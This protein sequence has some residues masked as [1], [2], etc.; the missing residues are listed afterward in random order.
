LA[1]SANNHFG[2]KCS[3]GWKGQV[4]MKKD[5]DRDKDGSRIE[6]R[7]QRRQQVST[8][9]RVEVG[10]PVQ[11]V[12]NRNR[13]ARL[14]EEDG[15]HLADIGIVQAKISVESDHGAALAAGGEQA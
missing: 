7:L 4:Y 11:Q 9:N 10:H 8:G 1:R 13:T 15:F 2:V 5:D 14:P 6:L 3:S 12:D